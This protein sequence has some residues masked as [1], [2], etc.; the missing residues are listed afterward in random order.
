MIKTISSTNLRNNLKDALSHVKKHKSP[1][2]ITDRDIPTAI[3][4]DV[5]EYEDF[6]TAKDKNFI[7]SIT[8]ARSQYIQG[9]VFKLSDVFGSLA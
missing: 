1:L 7:K 3:L 4:V 6:L 2:L 8:K 5:D 9:D